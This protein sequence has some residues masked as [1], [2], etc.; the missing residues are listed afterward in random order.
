MPLRDYGPPNIDWTD[1]DE[2]LEDRGPRLELVRWLGSPKMSFGGGVLLGIA[3]A[4][5]FTVGMMA[6][7]GTAHAGAWV[8]RRIP[9]KS[10]H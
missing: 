8:K 5:A 9:G 2:P 6:G 1:Y 4:G 7:S 3:L 10:R